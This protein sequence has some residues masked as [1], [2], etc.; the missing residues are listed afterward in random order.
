LLFAALLVGLAGTDAVP[1]AV[2]AAAAAWVTTTAL[3]R[4]AELAG[5]G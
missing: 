2:L 1:G 4:R 3:E 5:V